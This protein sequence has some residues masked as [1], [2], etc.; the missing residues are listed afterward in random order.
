MQELPETFSILSLI[1]GRRVVIV[2]INCIIFA[3]ELPFFLHATKRQEKAEKLNKMM[4]NRLLALKEPVHWKVEL[5][6]KELAEEGKSPGEIAET[7][8]DMFGICYYPK[9]V[10]KIMKE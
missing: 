5:A 4:T 6:I 2:R 10:R 8:F 3:A 9:K 1:N 7:I